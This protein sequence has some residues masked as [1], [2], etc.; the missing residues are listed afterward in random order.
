VT[1]GNEGH[2]VEIAGTDSKDNIVQNNFIGTNRE[3]DAPLGNAGNGILIREAPRNA[4]GDTLLTYNL[5]SGNIRNGVEISGINASANQVQGNMIG[6]NA[7]G[8]S[9]LS[10]GQDGVRI[11]GAPGNLIGGKTLSG[12]LG[13][14]L[15]SGNAGNGMAI[16]GAA[17]TG[18]RVQGNLIGVDQTGASSVGNLQNGVLVDNAPNTL[19]G[20]PRGSGAGNLISGNILHGVAIKGSG[21]TGTQVQGNDIGT[22][23][24]G[25]AAIGNGRNG[26]LI[27]NAP[28]NAIGG[29]RTNEFGNVVSGNVLNGVEISGAGA[30]GNLIQA[31]E[32]GTNLTGVTDLGNDGHGVA[33]TQFASGNTIGGVEADVFN[34]ILWN[35]QDGV[36]IASG[37]GNRILSNRI[38]RNSGLGIDLGDNGV[39][40]NDPGDT[41]SGAN[42]LQNFPALSVSGGKIFA[43]LNSTP[44]QEFRL[45]FFSNAVSDPTNYG[46]GQSFLKSL[47]VTTGPGGTV[48]VDTG[49]SGTFI[50]AT[51]T[52]PEGS[53]SE[54]SACLSTTVQYDY[55]D[56]PLPYP[57]PKAS[58]GAYHAIISP[59]Y[60]GSAVDGEPDGQPDAG[61]LGDDKNSVD[62]EDGV[63][64]P[65][66]I[67]KGGT[68]QINIIA[69]GNGLLNAW[70]DF[71]AD[72]DWADAGE[73]VFSNL[74]L[75][76]G[77]NALSFVVPESA[78]LGFTFSRFRFSTQSG[79]S[80]TGGAQD[81][82]VEDYR[83]E[84]TALDT[85]G[86][87]IPDS[88]EEGSCTSPTDPDS[89]GDGLWDGV[90]DANRN[91]ILDPGETDPCHFDTDRDGMPDG[92][93]KANGHDPLKDDSR[94]DADGDGYSNLR[95]YFSGTDPQDGMEIPPVISDGD[96][97]DDV[98]GSDLARL[99]VEFG[100]K[101]CISVRC[102][103]DL[104]QDGD[105]DEVDLLFFSEEFGIAD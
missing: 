102:G 38:F 90:E 100:T 36:S 95:E 57:T 64:F 94:L 32:I 87:G 24:A 78:A 58:N 54:F 60:L 27:D 63:I 20:G 92:Y 35:R 18:N 33:V 37:T 34:R 11:D 70:I 104:D 46:E 8:T 47:A 74:P 97:D 42:H 12:E 62:D 86:D 81:G 88:I 82:E 71:N 93:E 85:D 84:I 105:V 96:Q 103:G 72:G 101:D 80:F 51:A 10:N 75:V 43:T 77:T 65:P 56:A 83:I 19:I 91:G 29:S 73:K 40:M 55:G 28:G 5:I 6:L 52:G 23:A 66:A 3:G 26:I 49:L 53:T 25:S 45:E 15:I 30:T 50:S 99:A 98:D 67:M 16:T 59:L 22:D 21:A 48:T 39:T 69:S 9:A 79:L 89:D 7:A 44:S 41:D 68:A 14:N 17:A 31:N 61:A 13:A 4:I 1:S 76:F 2:G